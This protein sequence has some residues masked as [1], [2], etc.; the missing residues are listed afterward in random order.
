MLTEFKLIKSSK[1]TLPMGGI[2]FV[3]FFPAAPSHPGLFSL[4]PGFPRTSDS[5]S[6]PSV[7]WVLVPAF[8]CMVAMTAEGE[9]GAWEW[10]NVTF[11]STSFLK[12]SHIHKRNSGEQNFSICYIYLFIYPWCSVSVFSKMVG[13]TSPHLHTFIFAPSS[14]SALFLCRI[15]C[16]ASLKCLHLVLTLTGTVDPTN[17]PQL[18]TLFPAP[19]LKLQLRI[20]GR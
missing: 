14:L 11:I 1:F 5:H 8:V 2:P 18:W 16:S 7:L 17:A 10:G 4:L 9:G 15:V 19:P 20:W 3:S 13:G 12:D 6:S